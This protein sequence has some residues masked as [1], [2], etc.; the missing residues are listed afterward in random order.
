MNYFETAIVICADIAASVSDD[1]SEMKICGQPIPM[2]IS[3]YIIR[4]LYDTNYLKTTITLIQSLN[5]YSMEKKTK[6]RWI[7]QPLWR[8][9]T[10]WV[11]PLLKIL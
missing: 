10:F 11:R 9:W 5:S 1:G 4:K 7:R 6:C 8:T 3:G 2:G